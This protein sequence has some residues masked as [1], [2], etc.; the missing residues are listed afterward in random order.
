[1]EDKK[2]EKVNKIQNSIMNSLANIYQKAEEIEK[3]DKEKAD[4]ILK[5]VEE[6]RKD[7]SDNH[8]Q[9]VEFLSEI[10]L[11]Q[12][13]IMNYLDSENYKQVGTNPENSANNTI[14]DEL[15]SCG[16]QTISE[17][18]KRALLQNQDEILEDEKIQE[19]NQD[20]C[21]EMQ[22]YIPKKKHFWQKIL[23]KILNIFRQPKQVRQNELG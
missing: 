14:Q 9:P 21:T 1:M 5:R 12:T 15:L 3:V 7:I 18:D 22:I 2:D 10:M 20:E 4:W 19:Q 17:E 6:I 23:D 16:Q 13:E 11:L 8:T